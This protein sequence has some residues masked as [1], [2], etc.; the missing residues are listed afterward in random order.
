VSDSRTLYLRLLRHVK[1]YRGAFAGALAAMVVASLTEPAFPILM[2]PM[3]DGS[4][5][6]KDPTL[7][8]LIPI[9]LVAVFV[10]RGIAGFANKY[11]MTWV[12]SQ[13][14]LDLRAALFDKLLTLPTRYYD[15]RASSE[16]ISK[17]TY[18]VNQVASAATTVI[19]ALVKDSITVIGLL[20]WLMYLNW[21]LTLAALII[22]PPLLWIVRT[23][24]KR[25]RAMSREMQRS[26]AGIT[27]VVQET[28]EAHRV[29][30]VF[31]GQTYE[32]DRFKAAAKR[33]RSFAMKHAS[34][35]SA[36]VPL[37]ELLAAIA[38]ATIVFIAIQQS[39]TNQ[40]TPGGFISFI[41][42]MLMLLAP[43]KSLAGVNE[44]LQR[45]LA[46]AES[47]FSLLDEEAERDTGTVT[48]T[49]ARGEIRFDAVT[50]RYAG[51]ARA[52]LEAI[53]LTISPGET[54]ALVG[55]SGSGKT[56]F[57][58]LIA[59]LYT[60]SEGRI[61][62]DGHDTREVTLESL[63][64]QIALVSQDVVLF[65]DTVAA[66]IAYGKL[67]NT[68]E[69]KIIAAAEAAYAMEFIRQMPQGLQTPIGENGVKLSGGQRQRIAIARA[70]L[71][72]AP[73]LILD[74]ATSALDS[75]SERQV[76]AALENL[77]RGRTT[78][79]VAHR[80]STIEKADR[81]LVLEQ[82]RVVEMGSHA[83]LLRSGRAYAG[84]QR[85][86]IERFD[87][88]WREQAQGAGP[89]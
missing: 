35:A 4:F 17:I 74:E 70:L 27:N 45:G 29:V 24:S 31:G 64:A 66:N 5:V 20:A 46:A 8:K 21:K 87:S 7:M 48:L 47:A 86:Q 50:H 44:A 77:M 85:A 30:K 78:I 53:D 88:A 39:Q 6:Q 49:R 61:L 57:V 75:E 43:M 23:S 26:M 32:R 40:T 12:G 58:N 41:V 16:L 22:V 36:S 11:L 89:R 42:A 34:A 68:S 38:V 15:E 76:Q 73:I 33:V 19:T 79:V 18:D 9:A 82:G 2:K 56:T 28:V 65:N 83:E 37:V 84:L 55:Q 51:E 10:V 80:L 52:A 60:P 14:V 63:R 72:D 71:K 81:I 3:L 59:R 54:L 69:D 25:L 13:V 67:A 1:P 62:L